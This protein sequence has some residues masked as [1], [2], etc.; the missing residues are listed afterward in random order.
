MTCTKMTMLYEKYKTEWM[1]EHGITMSEFVR[2]LDNYRTEQEQDGAEFNSIEDVLD[3]FETDSNGFDGEIWAC[4][5]EWEENEFFEELCDRIRDKVRI[6]FG[7]EEGQ[8]MFCTPIDGH[9]VVVL[10][11]DEN[12]DDWGENVAEFILFGEHATNEKD[13]NEFFRSIIITW[14][15]LN[16][17]KGGAY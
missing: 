4:Y 8:I 12:H 5:D 9:E 2:V 16:D 1:L 7:D 10:S 14:L 11:I 6:G 17:E 13:E 3:S 15:W